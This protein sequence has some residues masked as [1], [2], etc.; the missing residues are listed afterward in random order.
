D[1]LSFSICGIFGPE[2]TDSD[3]DFRDL[4]DLVA[5]YK[6]TDKLTLKGN[7]DYGWEKNGG[8]SLGLN[9]K[10]A[11]WYGVAGYAKYDIRDWWSLAGRAEYFRDAE[12][13][14]TAGNLNGAGLP[15]LNNLNLF[16][17]TITNE[18]RLWKDLITRLEYRYDKADQQA[19]LRDKI[20]S[21]NQSTIS[22]EVA[23]KF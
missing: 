17:F 6:V 15:T 12:G 10:N 16:E 14:R 2:R 8:D 3:K 9:D 5:T 4:I 18:F 23:A 7:F 13:V 22:A 11:S 19:F 20:S 1:P 21:N